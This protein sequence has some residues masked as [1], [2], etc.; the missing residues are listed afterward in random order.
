MPVPE[1]TVHP[2]LDPS[3]NQR[4]HDLRVART[5]LIVT[6]V[7]VGAGI[8]LALLWRLR[9]VVLL[10]VVSLF[11]S[12]LLHP[13]VSFVERRGIRRGIA[14]VVVFFFSAVIKRSGSS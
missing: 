7:V 3:S 1:Q 4:A 10:I 14:T 12:A 13:V 2:E 11:L 6:G 9:V 8:G 5:A